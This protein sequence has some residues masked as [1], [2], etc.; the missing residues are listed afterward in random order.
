MYVVSRRLLPVCPPP[1]FSWLLWAVSDLWVAPRSAV[2]L[3]T[4]LMFIPAERQS[5]YRILPGECLDELLRTDKTQ[6]VL[7]AENKE[8]K[9]SGAEA[10]RSI[11]TALSADTASSYWPRAERRLISR[12]V[13]CCMARQE[14]CGRGITQTLG[15]RW[16]DR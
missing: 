5:K 11:A 9:Q 3:A 4:G 12:W 14:Y 13:I 1:T 16:M 8:R 10:G 7:K 6:S 2:R 15:F